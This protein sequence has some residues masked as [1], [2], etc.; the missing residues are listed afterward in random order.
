[1]M[2]VL[3]IMGSPQKG[4]TY[5]ACEGFRKNVQNGCAAEFEY[6]WLKD[7]DKRPCIGC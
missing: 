4:N 6:V 5:R 3:V 2:K 1:M 7:I